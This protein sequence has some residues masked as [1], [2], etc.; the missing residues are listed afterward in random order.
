MAPVVVVAGAVVIVGDDVGGVGGGGSGGGG[1]VI[2]G[3]GGVFVF[4]RPHDRATFL[5]LFRVWWQAKYPDLAAEFRRRMAGEL[6]EGW[7][8]SLPKFSPEVRRRYLTHQSNV[9]LRSVGQSVN[10]VPCVNHIK[11]SN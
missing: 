11:Q 1:G 6:P 4:A 2:F 10:S 5:F 9:S 7:K 8:D 3:D